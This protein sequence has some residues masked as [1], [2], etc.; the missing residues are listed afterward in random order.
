MATS[1][2]TSIDALTNPTGAS[3][4]TS[5]DHAGQHTD[6]NDAIEA[7]ETQIGT[8]AV[9]VL[10]RLASPTFTGTPTLP[11]GTIATT[12]TA[13]DSSTK[14]ATTAFV[15]TAD[16]LKANLASPTF[17]GVP[18]A[19][20]AT[21]GTNTTQLA[22]TAFVTTAA[23]NVTSGFRNVFI[24][25]AMQIAQRGTSSTS[26]TI[27]TY[28]TCDRW[29]FNL[30]SA[31]TWT[32]TQ[33]TDAPAGF[34]NSLKVQCTTANASLATTNNAR[35]WQKIEG[36]N[37][38]QFAKGTA[39]AK[40]LVLTFWVKAFQTGTFICTLDDLTNSRK[41]SA[42][43]TI[44]ASATWEK[45]TLFF[46][47][48]TTGALTND[49]SA[50]LMPTWWVAA[51]P[52][53]QGSALST[54]WSAGATL[55]NYADGQTNVAS[56]S[57]NYF[58][59]TGVQLEEGSVATPFEQRPYATELT[60]CERYFESSFRSGQPIGHNS[61]NFTVY[62]SD[63]LGCGGNSYFNHFYR[64][65]KRSNNPSLRVF[66]VLAA[67]PVNENWWRYIDACNPGTAVG[68][69]VGVAL[70][71]DDVCF[72]GYLQGGATGIAPIFDWTIEAEL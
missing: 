60:L 1:F 51:G 72:S 16:A 30:S 35:I 5:P 61:G 59:I 44:N 50:T 66:D 70:Y 38:Q 21:A 53:W 9:P 39:D 47:G 58:Q 52:S 41:I 2:P 36:F 19:P 54:S 22:T 56:S 62:P 23:A 68:P 28:P 67:H 64:T 27:S 13:A 65:R 32:A 25:G 45:K 6:A 15:T 12:Q 33:S 24:N 7:I 18:A 10:A 46:A 3:A 43:Y 8:T 14:V 57:N 20:T 31:G 69:N 71:P 29:H 26:I 17:T 63:S 55:S 11:T 49:S 4:L 48:D 37:V 42:S 40:P 34:S